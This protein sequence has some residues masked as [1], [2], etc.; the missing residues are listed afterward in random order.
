MKAPAFAYVKPASIDEVFALLDEYGDE[1]KILAGGQSLIAALNLRLSA[2][3]VLI[4]ISRI[5]D[6]AGI[7]VAGG[8]VAIG[9][10]VRHRELG[11]R[12]NAMTVWDVPDDTA[13]AAGQRIAA[14]PGVTLCYRRPRRL[15]TSGA[16]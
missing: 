13:A 14:M 7:R 16:R 6:L 12:A 8:K 4:D 10:L 11:Y 9:A 3:Q 2:P 1:A 15:L 5:R